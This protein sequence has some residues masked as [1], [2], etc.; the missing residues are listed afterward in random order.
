MR[1]LGS[2]DETPYAAGIVVGTVTDV[3]PD[4]GQLTRGATVRPAVDPD[5]IDVVAVLV[6]DRSPTPRP[7]TPAARTTAGAAR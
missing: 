1:T 3:D 4:R 2:V 5:A 6:P 7:A